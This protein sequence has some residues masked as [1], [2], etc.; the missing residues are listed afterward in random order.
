MISKNTVTA[1][2]KISFAIESFW[3]LEI[4]CGSEFTFVEKIFSFFLQ[5]I[6]NYKVIS[7]CI[8]NTF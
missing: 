6:Q 1:L 2:K 4:P 8:F 7:F 3:E 5:I